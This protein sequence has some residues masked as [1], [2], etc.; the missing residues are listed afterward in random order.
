VSSI[1]TLPAKLALGFRFINVGA[2]VLALTDYFGRIAQ[3]FRT[4]GE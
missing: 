3:A 1:E 4:T 2:D